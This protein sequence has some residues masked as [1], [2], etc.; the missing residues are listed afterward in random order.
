LKKIG[1]GHLP[2]VVTLDEILKRMAEY[3]PL[4]EIPRARSETARRYVL[5]M[6]LVSIES[7]RRYRI[8]LRAL[9]AEFVLPRMARFELAFF[10]PGPRL[11]ELMCRGASDTEWSR[12]CHDVVSKK[13]ERHHIGEPDF[14]PA[15]RTMVHIGG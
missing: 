13:E 7:L 14:V 12:S 1:C 5:M 9:Q 4:V 8:L 2:R 3:R 15:S 10:P 6:E 11:R